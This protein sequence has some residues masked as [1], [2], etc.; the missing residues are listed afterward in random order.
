MSFF[1]GTFKI[2]LYASESYSLYLKCFLLKSVFSSA[3][4]Q[5]QSSRPSTKLIILAD[6]DLFEFPLESLKIFHHN[7]SICSISRDFSLQFF[8]SRVILN[9]EAES[10]LANEKAN[11]PKAAKPEKKATQAV[12]VLEPLPDGAVV[13]DST[14]FKY[15]ID[16]FLE[17]STSCILYSDIFE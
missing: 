9:R 17:S 8:A 10:M 7:L 16:A 6:L 5:P 12:A 2:E 13:V 1:K 15:L 4:F 3:E 11:A 14:R